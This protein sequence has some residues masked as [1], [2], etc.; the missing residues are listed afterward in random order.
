MSARRRRRE[1]DHAAGD[2]AVQRR[3]DDGGAVLAG[4]REHLLGGHR[5]VARDQQRDAELDRAALGVG[6]VADHDDVALADV[7]RQRLDGHGQH[8]HA[9]GDLAL[10]AGHQ[11]ALGDLDD[12]LHRGGGVGQARRLAR[13]ADVAAGQRALGHHAGQGAVV[14]DDRHE[15]EVLARHRLPDAADGLAVAGRREALAHDVAHAQHDVGQE[16]GLLG[17]GALQHPRGLRVDVAEAHGDVVVARVQPA[18]ELGVADRRRDRV[19]VG[20]AVA[21]HVDGRHAAIVQRSTDRRRMAP[22][23]ARRGG[24]KTPPPHRAAVTSGKRRA[25]AASLPDMLIEPE[26]TTLPLSLSAGPRD[27]PLLELTIGEGLRRDRRA[28]RRP[29]GARRARAGLPRDL[30][31]AVGRGRPRRPRPARP[32]R[33]QGRSRGHLGAQ[34]LRVARHPVRHRAHRRDPRHHQPGLQGGRAG[35]RAEQDRREPARPRPRL[36]PG[37]LRRDGRRGAPALPAA[38]RDARPRGRLGATCSPTASGVAEADLAA[39]EATLRPRRPDQRPVH[40]GHDR[41][42][43]GRHALAP[44][45]PQQRLLHRADPALHRARPR[46]R[47]GALLPLLRHGAWPTWPASPTAPASWSRARTSTR[48]PRCRPSRRSAAPRSTACRRCSSPSSS[49]RASASSTSRACARG[50]WPARRAPSRS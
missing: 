12:R 15:L 16:L 23:A 34:P 38:A 8:P 36:P 39:V 2:V 4:E 43:Q 5:A 37:R 45:H 1:G 17:A 49:I 27:V 7:A 10:L 6:P 24:G 29:R 46:L 25:R 33:A 28:L 30:P 44:Q 50:S 19:G 3:A 41:R 40:L 22:L 35:V 26:A 21:R 32:R 48:W 31:R 20:V 13:L 9:P 18:L 14:V 42:P 47:A 11:P